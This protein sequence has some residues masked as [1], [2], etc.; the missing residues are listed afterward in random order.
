MP[1]TANDHWA[2][3][4]IESTLCRSDPK[5]AGMYAVFTHVSRREPS[6]AAERLSTWHPRS[7]IILGVIVVAA[8]I[9]SAFLLI[10][11]G[12]LGEV[13]IVTAALLFPPTCLRAVPAPRTRS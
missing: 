3:A 10:R 2:L 4:R 13:S 12:R 11:F 7:A 6:T 8:L 9:A 5:L 1:N